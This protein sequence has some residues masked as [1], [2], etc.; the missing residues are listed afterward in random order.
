M[1]NIHIYQARHLF[2]GDDYIG[3]Y[4]PATRTASLDEKFKEATGKVKAFI[5]TRFGTMAK[6]TFGA[7]AAE[8]IQ[9]PPVFPEDIV[10]QFDPQLGV[11]T[12]AAIE[13]ARDNFTP[14]EFKRAY[15][16]ESAYADSGADE[17]GGEGDDLEDFTLP[18]AGGPGTA[19]APL[20]PANPPVAPAKKAGRPSNAAKA[21]AAAAAVSTLPPDSNAAEVKALVDESSQSPA[22]DEGS[23]DNPPAT[24]TAPTE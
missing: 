14:A 12:P 1:N 19:S 9:P 15:G 23:G 13:W 6:V 7:E 24:T 20:V 4:N 5:S 3:K 21:A 11:R 17:G 10:E 22:A 2:Q 18:P 16:D 8:A